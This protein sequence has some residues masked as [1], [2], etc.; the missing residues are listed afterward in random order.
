MLGRCLG[1]L[2]H[3]RMRRALDE[4]DNG[5]E[6]GGRLLAGTHRQLKSADRLHVFHNA[7][8]HAKTQQGYIRTI[9]N[10]SGFLGRSGWRGV[11]RD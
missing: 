2:F 7:I 9:R 4:R 3:G 10:F 11:R 6:R 5:I 1:E 8:A